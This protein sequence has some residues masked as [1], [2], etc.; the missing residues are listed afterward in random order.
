MVYFE[1]DIIQKNVKIW[2]AFKPFGPTP[3]KGSQKTV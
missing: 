2:F 1:N 3:L